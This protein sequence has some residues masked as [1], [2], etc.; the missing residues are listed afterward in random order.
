MTVRPIR[1]FGDPILN[2][3]AEPVELFDDALLVLVRDMLE[4]MDAAGGVGLA[5]NQIGLAQRI[6]V[7]DCD[8]MRG[9]LINPEWEPLDNL[10]QIGAEGCL[11]IPGIQAEVQRHETVVARGLDQHGR[12]VTLRANG[13]LARC[14]QH[15]TDHLNGVLFL[16]RLEPEVR[17]EAMQMI[18]GM[19]WYRGDGAA[20]ANSVS[21]TSVTPVAAGALA[22]E[23]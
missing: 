13:L 11:S 1:I 7:Y 10:I 14:I 18:R 16:R 15:E 8:G 21:N 19:G 9:A 23:L 2:T 22:G 12:P 4:T 3:E 5:A 20:D 17:K 6:F